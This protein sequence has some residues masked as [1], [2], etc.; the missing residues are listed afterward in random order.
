M[1][2]FVEK[3]VTEYPLECFLKVNHKSFEQCHKAMSSGHLLTI[4]TLII[5][6]ATQMNKVYNNTVKIQYTAGRYFPKSSISR[7]GHGSKF[8]IGKKI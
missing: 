3:Y 7:I 8:S 5:Q 2:V 1:Q 4:K 6:P